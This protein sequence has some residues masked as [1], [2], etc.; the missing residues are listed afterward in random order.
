MHARHTQ[1]GEVKEFTDEEFEARDP[2]HWA[3]VTEVPDSKT[4]AKPRSTTPKAS[5][6]APK[7]A[8]PATE[9]DKTTQGETDPE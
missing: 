7:A 3:L 1:T 5:T 4:A 6:K 2:N 9:G 8:S